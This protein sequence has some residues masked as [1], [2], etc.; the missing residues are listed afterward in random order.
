MSGMGDD[1]S[2]WLT[3]TDTDYEGSSGNG[4][5]LLLQDSVARTKDLADRF[6]SGYAAIHSRG[7]CVRAKILGRPA[8]ELGDPLELT[9]TPESGL[10]ASGFVR[11]IRHVFDASE[12]FF[13]EAALQLE[14]GP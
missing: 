13:S 1:K 12:G 4:P 14:D 10:A 9:G 8:L 5:D 11:S 3:T 7:S 6:A 2:F